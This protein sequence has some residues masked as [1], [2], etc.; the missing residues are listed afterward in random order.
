MPSPSIQATVAKTRTGRYIQNTEIPPELLD[1]F[2]NLTSPPR[3]IAHK[4]QPDG[5]GFVLLGVFPISQ[6]AAEVIHVRV[7]ATAILHTTV[8]P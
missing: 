6:E 4:S 8:M 1:L 5:E 2:P 3:C 7:P